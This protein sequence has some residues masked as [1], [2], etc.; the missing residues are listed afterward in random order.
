MRKIGVLTSGG[1]TPGMNSAIRAVFKEGV[2]QN[3]TVLGI[4]HGYRGLIEGNIREMNHSD[5]ENIMHKGGTI[6]RTARSEEFKSPEG[7]KRALSVAKA[8]GIEGIVIIG[9][10]GSYRGAKILND[11]GVA[12]IGVPGT[13]DNDMGYTDYTIGFNTAVNTITYKGYNAR[14]RQSRRYRGNGKKL[15]RYCTLGRR[16][17]RCGHDTRSRV[18]HALG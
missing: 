15:R 11:L 13:I 16:C 4:F 3:F 1:D 7:Q 9:G 17:R 8:Y 14:T 10:D 2:K 18:P 6:L 5:V 12:T